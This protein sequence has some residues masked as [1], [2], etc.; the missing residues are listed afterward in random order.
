MP[1]LRDLERVVCGIMAGEALDLSSEPPVQP[2]AT[3]WTHVGVDRVADQRVDE[4]AGV[5]LFHGGSALAGSGWSRS[6]RRAASPRITGCYTEQSWSQPTTST[7]SA[8][9]V[10]ELRIRPS[11][12]ADE[13]GW[14]RRRARSPR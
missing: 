8:R 2:H 4:L 13:A 11:R 5:G 1:L 14:R 7:T 12:R 10:E 6:A 9:R 3:R